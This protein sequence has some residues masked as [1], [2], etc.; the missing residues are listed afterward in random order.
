MYL[1]FTPVLSLAL[2]AGPALQQAANSTAGGKS[3]RPGTPRQSSGRKSIPMERNG[4]CWKDA[5]TYREKRS[6]MLSSFP[7]VSTNITG[8]PQTRGLRSFKAY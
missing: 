2:G 4:P 3:P 8:T 5:A 6:P 1:L 7:R